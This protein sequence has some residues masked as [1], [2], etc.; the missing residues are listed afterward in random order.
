MYHDARELYLLIKGADWAE[1]V[2]L[3]PKQGAAARA[4]AQKIN[5]AARRS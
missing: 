2:E 5:V 3:K 1:V 4:L